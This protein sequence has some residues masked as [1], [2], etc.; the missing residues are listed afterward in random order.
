[1][2]RQDY[3]VALT[4]ASEKSEA[5]QLD[6]I[7]GLVRLLQSKGACAL[8]VCVACWGWSEMDRELALWMGKRD[9]PIIGYKKAI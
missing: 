9:V 2:E 6:S 4:P 5:S 3:K 8:E 1:M 7:G